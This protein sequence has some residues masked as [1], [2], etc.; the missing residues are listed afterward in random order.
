MA[1]KSP[2][3]FR[4]LRKA[5]NRHR[6][7]LAV[8][9]GQR[10][11][12][13]FREHAPAWLFFGRALTEAA[14]YAEARDAISR[15]LELAPQ[16]R[17]A[18]ILAQRGHTEALAG[19]YAAAEDWYRQ[20]F[21]SAPIDG[22]ERLYLGEI[23]FRQG[24]LKEAEASLRV[25][26]GAWNESLHEAWHLLGEVLASQERYGEALDCFQRAAE[27]APDCGKHARRAR[28]LRK[29]ANRGGPAVT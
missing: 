28:E 19:D 22:E 17:R 10:Y 9:L 21:A 15:A 14:R 12:R 3:L 6:C 4:R 24:K 13:R 2:K 8:A 7:H 11:C 20:A 25:V 23:L 16:D 5:S 18:T 1:D 29:L 27:S 26:T